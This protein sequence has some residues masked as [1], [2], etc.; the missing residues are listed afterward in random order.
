MNTGLWL[1]K[2]LLVNTIEKYQKL[3]CIFS[4]RF[5]DKKAQWLFSKEYLIFK[6]KLKCDKNVPSAHREWICIAILSE[7]KINSVKCLP[8]K[9]PDKQNSVCSFQFEQSATK[10]LFNNEI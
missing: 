6:K 9:Q 3:Q 5:F 7:D 4:F 10:T 1:D 2:N 8:R